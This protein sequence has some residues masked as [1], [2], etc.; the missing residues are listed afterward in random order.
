MN[1]QGLDLDALVST[2]E[3]CPGKHPTDLH[4][5]MKQAASMLGREFT[6]TDAAQ[7]SGLPEATL[8]NWLD[9]DRRFKWLVARAKVRALKRE[10][11]HAHKLIAAQLAR[12]AGTPC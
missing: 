6:L 9:S 3:R 1:P 10:A 2:C 7:R 12:D 11:R 4:R 8:V 5:A